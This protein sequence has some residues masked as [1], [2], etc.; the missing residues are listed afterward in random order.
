MV[1]DEAVE[2]GAIA[3]CNRPHGKLRW[4]H[5]TDRERQEWWLDIEAALTAAMPHILESLVNEAGEQAE[6]G[7]TALSAAMWSEVQDWLRNRPEFTSA[8]A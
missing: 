4:E 7:Q 2:A 5:L 6:T 3:A 8:H 1:N